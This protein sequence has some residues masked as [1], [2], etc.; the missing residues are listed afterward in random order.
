MAEIIAPAG[1]RTRVFR[2]FSSSLIQIIRIDVAPVDGTSP[3]SG[4]LEVRG[5]KWLFTRP[6]ETHP[7][8][9]TMSV[10]KG[11]WD[12]RYAIYVIP[13]VDVRVTVHRPRLGARG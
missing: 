12:T 13:D 2:R 1:E 7:L 8:Q 4:L 5:S 9:P 6:P 11:Y 3:V 10:R